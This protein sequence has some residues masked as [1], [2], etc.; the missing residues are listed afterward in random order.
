MSLGGSCA[1]LGDGAVMGYWGHRR[2]SAS[3]LPDGLEPDGSAFPWLD[4]MAQR[5]RA[6]NG[7]LYLRIDWRL[8]EPE[9]RALYGY[10]KMDPRKS[11]DGV[12]GIHWGREPKL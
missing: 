4:G 6:R 2:L 8:G 9:W 7:R 5:F 12:R 3:A 10:Q 11:R 1:P